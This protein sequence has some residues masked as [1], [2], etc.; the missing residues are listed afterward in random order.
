MSRE[1]PSKDQGERRWTIYVCPNCGKR[2]GA[3]YFCRCQV[4][5]SRCAKVEVVPA[6]LLTEEQERVER[7]RRELW[8]RVQ[9]ESQAFDR[10]QK[11]GS[12]KRMG[13]ASARLNAFKAA[14]QLLAPDQVGEEAAS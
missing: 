11:D 12:F 2:Q 13:L 10:A 14:A 6:A 8:W 3:A 7:V 5:S 1:T 4:P 9:D